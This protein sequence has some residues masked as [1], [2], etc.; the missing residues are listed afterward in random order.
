MLITCPKC[1][2][3]YQIPAEVHLTAGRKIQ[4]SNCHYV[5]S[6]KEQ[7]Q[8]AED[9]S[10]PTIEEITPATPVIEKENPVIEDTTGT[11]EA[12]ES[13][14]IFADETI[15][16]EDVPQPFM[17]VSTPEAPE[18]KPV[19]LLSVIVCSFLLVALA[20]AGFIYRD[21][22]FGDQILTSTNNLLTTH[23]R[24]SSSTNEKSTQSEKVPNGKNGATYIEE[25]PQIVL[26]P[27]IQ[28]VR[29]EKQD[30]PTP[31]IRIEG[32]LKNTAST[33]LTLPEK[34]RAVA[35][36]TQGEVLFEKEIYLTDKVLPAGEERAFFG[37]YQPA[38]S[39]VQWIEV[40]F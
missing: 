37:S 10:Q 3:K 24:P 23:F 33:T 7:N 11:P 39:N 21:L 22:L 40:T 8:P 26:L 16:Q 28:S 6:L 9:L 34:V 36:D 25:T 13:E 30:G 20:T 27:Q 19:S 12:N 31:T 17:P 38:P 14:S 32:I 1:A 4:C 15:F 5:F 2:A 18:K 29:F 35:Y